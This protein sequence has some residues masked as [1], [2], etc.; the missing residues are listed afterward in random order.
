MEFQDV[1]SALCGCGLFEAGI[2]HCSGCP[3]LTVATVW[4]VPLSWKVVIKIKEVTLPSK[5]T[6]RVACC[7]G[8]GG[9]KLLCHSFIRDAS[10]NGNLLLDPPLRD[11]KYPAPLII[12]NSRKE[13][14]RIFIFDMYVSLNL[15]TH[16]SSGYCGTTGEYI[17]CGTQYW[18]ILTSIAD[19]PWKYI[20]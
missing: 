12:I 3:T 4:R 13:R 2:L 8:G 19:I 17:N 10:T 11:I 5:E 15:H 7:R 18:D 6:L 14:L 20:A 16:Q 1:I 9:N